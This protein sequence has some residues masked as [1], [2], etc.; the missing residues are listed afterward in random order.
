MLPGSEMSGHVWIPDSVDGFVIGRVVDIRSDS[1]TVQTTNAS[2][3]TIVR[4]DD[5]FPA[6]DDCEKDFEDNC[7]LMYLNEATLLHNCRQRYLR[8]QFYTYV[9]NILIA[10]NP[11]EQLTDLYETNIMENYRGKSIGTL[12]PHIFAIADNSYRDMLRMRQSQSIIISGESGAGKTES[13]KQVLRYLCHSYGESDGSVEQRLLETN[14]ILESFGNAKTVRN[15]NS[16]RFGKFVEVHF[17]KKQTI[18]GGLVSH[19][20]LEKSRICGQNTAERNYHIFYQLI[21]GADDQL[22]NR[23]R[24]QSPDAYCYLNKGCAQFFASAESR[25]KIPSFRRGQMGTDLNDVMV[26]DYN[27]FGHL[28]SAFSKLGLSSEQVHRVF[29]CVAAVLHLGNIHFS[30]KVE[31]FRGKCAIDSTSE[32]SLSNASFLLGVDEADLRRE[33]LTRVMQPTR[34]GAKGTLYLVPLKMSE[35]CAARNALA[36]AIYSRLFDQIV[37]WINSSIPFTES[38]TYIGVL[39]AAGFEF[40][41]VNSFEQFC[42]NFSNEKLQHFFNECVL[43]NEQD[44][45]MKEGLSFE[46]VKYSD[47]QECIDLFEGKPNGLFTLLDDEARLPRPSCKH[48]T[49]A[50][51]RAHRNHALLLA[52]RLSKIREQRAM[53]DDDGFVIRHYASPVCY[54]TTQ[55]L[56]KN[57]DSL[58]VSLNILMEQSTNPLIATLF[59][60]TDFPTT[61]MKSASSSKKLVAESV[62]RKFRLQLDMLI[63][64]LR[65]TG[66]HFVRCIKP[67]SE[68]TA[69]KFDGVA[70]LDQLKCAGMASVMRVM[71][72]GFP[73]RTSFGEIVEHYRTLLPQQLSRLDPRLFCKCLFHALGLNENDFA[74][75]LTKAFF[76]AGKFAQFDQMLRQDKAEM[77]RLITLAASWLYR[78]RWRKLQCGVLCTIK[79]QLR[80]KYRSEQLRIIQSHVRGL[81]ARRTHRPRIMCL[82]RVRAL[83]NNIDEMTTVLKELPMES[84][85]R[86]TPQL[87]TMRENIELL[88]TGIKR[89]P[90]MP[91]ETVTTRYEHLVRDAETL[92]L[93]LRK[94]ISG[95]EKDSTQRMENGMGT[96]RRKEWLR[97]QN[98]EGEGREQVQEQENKRQFQKKKEQEGEKVRETLRRETMPSL[99]SYENEKQK[100]V[101]IT[102]SAIH[103]G[104]PQMEEQQHSES[105]AVCDRNTICNLDLTK[106]KYVDLR[107]AITSSKGMRIP[108][109]M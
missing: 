65:R 74:F 31:D 105:A 53:H 106:W 16:S 71:Q 35:A 54:D 102:Q 63:D 3:P 83:T 90:L 12:R 81:I 99:T 23:L 6:E 61:A 52:P 51:H 14:A 69:G 101:G 17:G 13:Q 20:L 57:N 2:Q 48:F 5:V 88:V 39:D 87:E 68:M 44:F 46:R 76:R 59:H 85:L 103:P 43:R 56:E 26:D 108:V 36:K 86:W 27:D 100:G 64:K 80:M 29:E 10:I 72:A 37:S 66:T 55:F 19:Y 67:N 15:N 84:Q 82:T 7:S 30:E 45:Y 58:H 9:A 47:N 109:V 89:D 77:L 8:K 62:S 38:A 97:Q 32:P 4:Y 41:S 78:A 24:L 25:N 73:S 107:N 96:E 42:I 40:F 33:L 91:L 50:V 28:I 92:L 95:D 93:T 98:E 34:G 18:A 1:L 60:Q 49:A 79:L 94:Q 70:I 21:A 104:K 11:Y 22:W 75:G